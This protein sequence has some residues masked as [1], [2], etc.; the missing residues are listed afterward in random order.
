[1]RI[2]RVAASTG[3]VALIGG[4]AVAAVVMSRG[5]VAERGEGCDTIATFRTMGEA[6]GTDGGVVAFEG[7]RLDSIMGVIGAYY[8]RRVCFREE[9]MKGLRLHTKWNRR[10]PLTVFIESMNEL[11]GLRISDERDTLFVWKGGE[12]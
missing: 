1:M 8:G 3:L 4:L 11:D 7:A 9:R 5:L 12:E 10:E 2:W 6:R